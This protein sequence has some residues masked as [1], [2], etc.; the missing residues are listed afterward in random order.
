MTSDESLRRRRPALVPTGGGPVRGRAESADFIQSLDRGLAA[1]RAFS[2]ERAA[3]SVSEVAR[4]AAV[5]RAAARRILFTLERLGYAST[6]DGGRFQLEPAVLTLGYAYLSSQGISQLAKSYMETAANAVQGSCTLAV[7]EGTDVLFIARVRPPRNLGTTYT[8]GSRIPAHLTSMGRCLLADRSDE[9]IDE[10][11]KNANLNP[12]TRF[13]VTDPSAIRE[14]IL[15]IRESGYSVVNQELTIGVLGMG[16]SIHS[17]SSRRRI[18]CNVAVA[19]PGV[20]PSKLVRNHLS[21]L[22]RTA[23]EIGKVLA[24][25]DA[26][27]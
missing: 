24:T 22:R 21:M 26:D 2:D 14:S 5:S 19:D 6:V 18:A 20:T 12:F 4:R 3:L 13:T 17:G 16:V 25:G 10:Y 11:L 27:L 9:E 7:L 8:I 23:E 15:E 1:I